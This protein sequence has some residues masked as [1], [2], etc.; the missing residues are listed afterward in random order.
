MLGTGD[1]AGDKLD[2]GS[3]REDLTGR[4]QMSKNVPG[5]RCSWGEDNQGERMGER[6]G[7]C[8][9]QGVGE[10]HSEQVTLEMRWEG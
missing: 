7:G 4:R 3:A 9:K 2:T 8:W 10:G 1:F 6:M 5:G